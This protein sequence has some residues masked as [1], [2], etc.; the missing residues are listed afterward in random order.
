MVHAGKGLAAVSVR[1]CLKLWVDPLRLKEGMVTSKGFKR[2]PHLGWLY[3]QQTEQGSEGL[4][5]TRTA[6]VKDAP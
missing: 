4:T 2:L 6:H 3:T 1:V 5:V